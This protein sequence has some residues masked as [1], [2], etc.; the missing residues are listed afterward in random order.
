[1]RVT[2]KANER[3][4]KFRKG[5][6][7]KRILSLLIIAILLLGCCS[8]LAEKYPEGTLYKGMKGHTAEIRQLQQWLIDLDYLDDKADGKFGQN[9]QNAV[10]AF[11]QDHGLTVDGEYGPKSHDALMAEID[12]L[13]DI[14][15]VPSASADDL[16]GKSGEWRVRT[17][18]DTAYPT[19]GF[20]SGGDKLTKIDLG[21]WVPVLFGGEVRFIS[22]EALEVD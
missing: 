17:G 19:A 9:T 7:M 10:K 11:Q 8:A 3:S 5:M 6:S 22:M 14:P 15:S 20:A 1:M 18:P 4:R 2:L 21:K 16:V 13:N 12:K